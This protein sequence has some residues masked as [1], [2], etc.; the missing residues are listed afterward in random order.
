MVKWCI[1]CCNN[2]YVQDEEKKEPERKA[3]IS[4]LRT[5]ARKC[6]EFNVTQTERGVV[7]DLGTATSMITPNVDDLLAQTLAAVGTPKDEESLS[8][9]AEGEEVVDDI[10]EEE[11]EEE[12]SNTTQRNDSIGRDEGEIFSYGLMNSKEKKVVVALL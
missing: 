12:K 9:D 4:E 8:S 5:V 6:L 7:Q 2:K 10:K 1:D 3:S 11:G